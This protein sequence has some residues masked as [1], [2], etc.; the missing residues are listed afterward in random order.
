[1]NQVFDYINMDD[2]FENERDGPCFGSS[3][4]QKKTAPNESDRS[5]AADR[6]KFKAPELKKHSEL[7]KSIAEAR[8]DPVQPTG[9]DA[10]A[11]DD[12]AEFLKAGPRQRTFTFSQAESPDTNDRKEDDEEEEDQ[13][14]DI[15]SRKEEIKKQLMSLQDQE[16]N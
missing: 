8:T 11:A 9:E 12:D 16:A 13:E 3:A 15:Q 4:L 1:M 6:E 5:P 7:K 10:G 14:N 2:G